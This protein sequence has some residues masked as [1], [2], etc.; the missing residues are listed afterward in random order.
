MM[1]LFALSP[2]LDPRHHYVIVTE[3]KFALWP[4][5][6]CPV[7]SCPGSSQ[8]SEESLEIFP[9]AEPFAADIPW[10]VTHVGLSSVS[11]PRVWTGSVSGP[12]CSSAFQLLSHMNS[13][14]PSPPLKC[15]EGSWTVRDVWEGEPCCV[16]APDDTSGICIITTV[17][18]ESICC[19]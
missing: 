2:S 10:N 11:S 18:S 5:H 8:V 7:I 15:E 13:S 17:L 4:L 3:V 12:M 19:V 9:L 14:S 6:P 16:L 1:L